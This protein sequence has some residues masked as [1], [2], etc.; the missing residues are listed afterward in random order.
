MQEVL[1]VAGGRIVQGS[2]QVSG[3]KNAALPLLFASLLSSEECCLNNVPNLEDI[4]VTLRLLRSLGAHCEYEGATLKVR[5]R[6]IKGTEAPYGLV[7]ALRASFWVLGPLLARAHE[8]RVSLPGGDAI[9]TRPV[10][11]HLNGLAKL[12]ANFRMEHGVVIGNAPGG[13]TGAPVHLDFP[14]V[15]ATHNILMAAVLADGETV[16]TGAAREP[17]VVELA[18]YLRG[19]GADIEGEGSE[20]I[21]VIGRSELGG[22]THTVKGDRIEAA[23]YLLCGAV[24]G[25]RVTVTG[26]SPQALGATLDVL[27]QAGCSVFS[28]ASGGQEAVVVEGVARFSP[29]SFETSPYPGVATDVQ[30]LLMAALCGADGLSKI[31]E[32]VF[33]NRFGHV[34]EYRRLGANIA[35]K[36][37]T[38]EIQGVPTLSAA[39]VEGGDIRAAAGLV[40]IALMS[41]GVTQI[42]GLHHLDRG[43]EGLVP[44]LRKLGADISRLPAFEEKEV[45]V[46]C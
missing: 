17:E 2:V 27:Q 20:T 46:G 1:C 16:I 23:T 36:G 24:T 21:R 13:L 29:V 15:G 37:R 45:V 28:E 3:A 7:K 35:I 38:A 9:G 19:M 18:E 10:D 5:V 14:S 44:K 33:E 34:A 31:H 32:T 26:I 11:L 30:P 25:G 12:G 41:E 8:A 40:V 22:V 42:R 6:D 43:Y 4:P 39:P